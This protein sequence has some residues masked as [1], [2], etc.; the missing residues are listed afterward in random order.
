M[1]DGIGDLCD[2]DNPIPVIAT[3]QIR[4]LKLPDNGEVVGK[5]VAQRSRRRGVNLYHE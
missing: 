4:F 3:S 2:T 5:I 1:D